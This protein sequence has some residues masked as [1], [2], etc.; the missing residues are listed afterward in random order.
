VLVIW[1]G[2]LLLA[3][4]DA[5][6]ALAEN[7]KVGI[8]NTA[9]ILMKSNYALKMK[10]EFLGEIAEQRKLLDKKR[11]V[12][13]KLGKKVAAAKAAG[14]R[15]SIVEKLENEYVR[16]V[17]EMNWMKEDF[18]KEVREMDKALLSKM[19]KRIRLV[20]DQFITV[21]DYCIILEKQRVAVYCDSADVTDHIIKRLDSYRD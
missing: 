13:E 12:V 8:I 15:E 18:D 5:S 19:K 3:A 20:L 21:T 9:K 7:N 11:T 6:V 16:A 10:E 2:F 14:K 4:A 1:C 17:R